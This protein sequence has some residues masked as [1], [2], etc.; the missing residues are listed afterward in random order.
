MTT[1]NTPTKLEIAG[2]LLCLADDMDAV[3][4]AMDYYGGLAPWA[5]HA[6]EMMGAA[7][8]CRDWAGEIRQDEPVARVAVEADV[9][10]LPDCQTCANRGHVAGLSQ[11]TYCEQCVRGTPWLSD[12]Y[13]PNDKG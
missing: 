1:Q 3:A 6:K 12:H 2:R 13:R 9:R 7:V 11:E 5:A 4:L 10:Q 8:L